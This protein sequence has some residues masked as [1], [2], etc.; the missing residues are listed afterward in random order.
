VGV[1]PTLAATPSDQDT[2]C[3]AEA[4]SR[5]ATAARTAPSS[6]RG[7]PAAGR[8]RSGSQSSRSRRR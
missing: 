3:E 4:R 7:L 5:V 8:P 1:G 2:P 6:G